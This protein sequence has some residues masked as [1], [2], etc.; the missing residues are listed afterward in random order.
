[1]SIEQPVI[2]LD[3]DNHNYEI[4]IVNIDD[5]TFYRASDISSILM[6]K[7]IHSSIVNVKSSEKFLLKSKTKGGKQSVLY[8]SNDAIKQ[9]V[10]KS[11]SALAPKLAKALGFDILNTYVYSTESDTIEKI[12]E[13]FKGEKMITQ[14]VV[15]NYKID[16]Y[17]PDYKLAIECDEI[18]HQ[19][20]IVSTKDTHRQEY[21]ENKLNCKFIRFAPSNKDF[22][23]FQIIN[24]IYTHIKINF[25]EDGTLITTYRLEL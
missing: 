7:N 12:M 18:Y 19:K 9:I 24:Q 15:G 22:N 16:L 2:D 20:N 8:L 11:R 10:S 23:I 5:K 14:Y 13:S 17:F 25:D 4:K 1:M 6:I 21:I 3:I